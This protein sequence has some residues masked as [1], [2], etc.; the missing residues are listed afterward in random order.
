MKDIKLSVVVPCYNEQNRFQKGFDHYYSYLN[1]QKYP[2]E[3][4]F[5][6][7]GSGDTTLS[8]MEA[9]AKKDKRVRI[10][11]YHENHGKGYAIVQGIKSAAGNHIL[12]TD[13]D[14]SVNIDTIESFYKYFD[15]GYKVVIGSRRVKGAKILIRQPIVREYMG[16]CFTLLVNIFVGWGIADATCG[17][18]AFENKTAQ[19]LFGKIS[20][21]GWAFDAE[22]LFL[23]KKYQIKFAQAPVAWSDVRGSKV[24]LG[25]DVFK[26][27]FGL[28][29]IRA[30]DILGNY[31][32]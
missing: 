30:N 16:R 5:V 13:I 28:L 27:F 24:T 8:L 18:K 31:S 14:H 4:I 20:I 1:K 25:R 19:K 12:F 6:N 23:C 26:S 29:K 22:I 11:T 2:W 7:D 3:L 10:V 9:R 32:R 15:S 17:F 21:Y